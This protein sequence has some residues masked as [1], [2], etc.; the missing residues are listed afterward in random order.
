MTNTLPTTCPTC[1]HTLSTMTVAHHPIDTDTYSHEVYV[2]C[3]SCP[4]Y[5]EVANVGPLP[6]TD[7]VRRTLYPS[8]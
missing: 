8:N 7:E 4:T 5:A 1:G 6:M 3:P 2:S